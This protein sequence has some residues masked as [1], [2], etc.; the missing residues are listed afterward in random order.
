M[1]LAQ[2]LTMS[3][4][5]NESLPSVLWKIEEDS[6]DILRNKFRGVGGGLKQATLEHLLQVQ[7]VIRLPEQQEIGLESLTFALDNR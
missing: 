7:W 2:H 1:P 4:I 3:D 6:N 5:F